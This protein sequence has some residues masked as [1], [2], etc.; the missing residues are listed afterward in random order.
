MSSMAVFLVLGGATAFAALGK[1][2]VGTKQL[3]KNA[4]T[5]AKIKNNAVTTAK[6]KNSAVTGA[7]LNESTL[8]QVPS[9]ANADNATNATNAGNA[10]TVGGNTVRKMLYSANENTGTQTVLSLNGLTITANCDGGT[11][12]VIATTSVN[13]SLIHSG[14]TILGDEAFYN[15][16]DSFEIGDEHEIT[17]ELE[18]DSNQGTFTYANPTG[19]VVTAVWASEEGSPI[20]KDCFFGGH[21]TS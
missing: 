15:E 10:N 13:D 18:A 19:A 8:G 21:A 4:V 2:T 5:T 17:A 7:K 12:E 9:A 1:N 3:K 16:E 11:L 14:G 20:G 6:I